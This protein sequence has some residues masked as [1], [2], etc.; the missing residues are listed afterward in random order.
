MTIN[1]AI[2]PL[3]ILNKSVFSFLST[4]DKNSS[5]FLIGPLLTEVTTSLALRP[6]FHARLPR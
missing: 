4:A 3:T 5:R 1:V 6:L 2:F